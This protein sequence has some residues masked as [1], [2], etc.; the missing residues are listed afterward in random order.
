MAIWRVEG[1]KIQRDL[2][3]ARRLLRRAATPGHPD[4]ELLHAYFGAAGVGGPS[5]WAASV[6]SLRLLASHLSSAERQIALLDRMELNDGGLPSCVPEKLIISRAPYVA[7]CRS[8]ISTEEA[9]YIGAK[10]SERL[11]QS[12]V[13]DPRT[14]LQELHPIRRSH[15]AAFGVFDEDLVICAI[16]RR[17]AVISDTDPSQ[18]EPL[19]VLRYSP[20]GE[21]RAHSDT[22][23]NVENQRILT[24]LVY[25]N[26]GYEGGETKFVR[27]GLT[28]EPR[29]GDALL[30]HNV[31][32][33][34]YP[35]PMADHA[36][37][38]VTKGTKW[39]AT[40]WIRSGP[41]AFSPPRPVLG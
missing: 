17:I 41:Y 30:F 1:S 27:S 10:S 24:V 23:V 32:P 28:V 9:E 35:D 18:G 11:Q 14:G 4:A 37:L 2:V 16:N 36:G 7:Q 15:E 6:A 13:V 19:R 21:Y 31:T 33:D 40:R 29:Q 26:D 20:G 39:L 34:G 5:D 12:V 38:Q 3:E 8:F 22:L 25:L